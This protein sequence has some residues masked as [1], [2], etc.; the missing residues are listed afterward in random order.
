MNELKEVY[1]F[2]NDLKENNNRDWFTTNKKHF[3]NAKNK[4]KSFCENIYNSISLEDDLESMKIFRIYRDVR[5]SKDKTPYKVNFGASFVRQKPQLRGGYY[6]HLQ[7]ENTFVGGGFW[8]PNK[9]DLFRIR[10]EFEFDDTRIKMILNDAKFKS[11]FGELV[12]EE[13][14]T[15]PKGFD[16]NH[17]SINLIKKK[18]FLIVKKYSDNDVFSDKFKENIVADFLTMIPF[19]NYMS[20]VLTTDLNGESVI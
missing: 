15:A 7:P 19:F 5:F 17:S 2:L 3:E 1:R 9:E 18:Q 12:G 16:K 8:Q 20:E 6:L 11:T 10:K 14:K 4:A 13:L